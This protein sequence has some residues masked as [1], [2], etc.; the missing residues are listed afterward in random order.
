MAKE[1][2]LNKSVYDICAADAVAKGILLELGFK[3]VATP[4]A[5]GAMKNRRIPQIVPI[6]GKDLDA[7]LAAFE[8]RG[9]TIINRPE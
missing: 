2:D 6:K 1:L 7:V 3:A 4:K 9:Y 5:M 8:A